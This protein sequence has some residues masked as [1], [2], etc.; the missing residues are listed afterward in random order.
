MFFKSFFTK[1]Q[2]DVKIH[3][4][5]PP[6]F[7]EAV[8]KK[9]IQLVDVRTPKEF[10]L[11]K[12]KGAKNINFFDSFAFQ[13]ETEKLNKEAAV[14]LYCQSGNRSKRASKQLVK[15][16]FSQVYDLRGGYSNWR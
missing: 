16:G 14:Y 12:I 10:T 11:G 15:M 8:N 5:S 9:S 2:S 3:L 7:K 4:L 6:E 13:N 1:N